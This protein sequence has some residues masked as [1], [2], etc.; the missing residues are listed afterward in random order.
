VPFFSVLMPTRNR[1]SLLRSSLESAV[2]QKFQD[3]EIIVSDNNSTDDTKAVVEHFMT[4]SDKISYVNPGRDLSMCD[5]WEYVLSHARGRYIIYLCDDDALTFDSLSYIHELLAFFKMNVLVW[6]SGG[7]NHPDIPHESRLSFT[8]DY[9][10]SELFEVSSKPLVSALCR[11]DWSINGI[12]PKMLNC[13]VAK[14]AIDA[15]RS[16][17]K[18]FFV[19]P[20]PD[21]SAVGQL[22]STNSS[23]HFIDLPLYIAG[24]SL[25]SN[26]GIRFDRKKKHDEY[27]SLF[28]RDLLEGV[29]YQMPYLVTSYFYATWLLFRRIYPE[30]FTAEIDTEEYLKAL[31][32]ELLMFEDY[33]DISE[34][35]DQLSG[36]MRDFS[37]SSEMFE[38]LWQEHKQAKKNG[39]EPGRNAGSVQRLKSMAWA[40]AGKNERAFNFLARV[41][42]HKLQASSHKNVP[43]IGAA[44][45]ILSS[46]LTKQARP[47]AELSPVQV[48]SPKFLQE[49]Q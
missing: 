41:R 2:N 21:F 17:T 37:G 47:V 33:E 10:S 1:A 23:Y 26:A 39:S 40:F 25:V 29:P 18:D 45:N 9:G 13:A 42:G 12:V 36:Y 19:P 34:E 7:Y 44:A 14:D 4:S 38:R 8:Y 46:Y 27:V 16:Q 22:L 6:R 43:S 49:R 31:F 3:Y 20:Y 28:G 15:C 30:T 35:L 48:S 32:S 5:N 24:A 11:F